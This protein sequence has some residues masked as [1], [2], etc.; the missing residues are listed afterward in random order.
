MTV[1]NT[2]DEQQTAGTIR[3]GRKQVQIQLVYQPQERP[4]AAHSAA[5]H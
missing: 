1:R 5:L 4:A 2:T 3:V